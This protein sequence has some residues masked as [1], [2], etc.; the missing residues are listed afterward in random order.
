MSLTA[1]VAREAG[2]RAVRDVAIE[3]AGTKQQ[4]RATGRVVEEAV[5]DSPVNTSGAVES[6]AAGFFGLDL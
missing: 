2:K 6:A 5:R 3:H 1:I 4:R